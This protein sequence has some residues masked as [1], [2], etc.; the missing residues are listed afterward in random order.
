MDNKQIIETTSKE[1]DKTEVLYTRS[2]V[3]IVST[4][5]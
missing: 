2:L 4:I 1:G 5:L 3:M